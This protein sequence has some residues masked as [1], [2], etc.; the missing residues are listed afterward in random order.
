MPLAVLAKGIRTD[1]QLILVAEKV[2]YS[3]ISIINFAVVINI[4]LVVQTN[5][6]NHA[7]VNFGFVYEGLFAYGVIGDG[8]VFVQLQG[9]LTF[10]VWVAKNVSEYGG[11]VI[12]FLYHFGFN[13][14]SLILRLG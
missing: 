12:T 2:I 1:L 13:Y 4:T 3:D 11:V 14:Y 7:L 8:S 6:Q 5:F 9:F 10:G